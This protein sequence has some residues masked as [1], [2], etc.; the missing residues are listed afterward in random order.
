MRLRG[1]GLPILDSYGRT[2]GSGDELVQISIYVPEALNKEEKN[3]MEKLQNSSNFVPNQ[4]LKESIF[5]KFRKFF[6]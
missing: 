4:S 3:M 1:K 2:H 5:K 6:D